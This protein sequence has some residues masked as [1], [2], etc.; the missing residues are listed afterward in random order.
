MPKAALARTCPGCA[1]H[2][3]ASKS[4]VDGNATLAAQTRAQSATLCE[5]Y[6]QNRRLQADL[7]RVSREL[8]E[9][10]SSDLSVAQFAAWREDAKADRALK[11][12]TVAKVVEQLR[13]GVQ[14]A[15]SAS[16]APGLAA[17]PQGAG[18]AAPSERDAW[19][20]AASTAPDGAV[21]FLV[22]QVIRRLAPSTLELVAT[23][24]GRDLLEAL[25]VALGNH[26]KGES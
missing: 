14:L 20:A 18:A 12:E 16:V 13:E 5:V 24:A 4:L 7:D 26:T 11:R 9:A 21:P 15:I 6:D 8:R 1:A 25:L 17:A 22:V 10:R 19:I 2:A 3:E 23:D